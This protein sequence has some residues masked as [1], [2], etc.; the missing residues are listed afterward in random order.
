MTAAADRGSWFCAT[1]RLEYAN[2]GLTSML[3]SK[4]KCRAF[5]WVE[6]K[7]RKVAP[8]IRSTSARCDSVPRTYG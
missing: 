4:M 7:G 1:A 2:P 6:E 5:G 8:G 3:R